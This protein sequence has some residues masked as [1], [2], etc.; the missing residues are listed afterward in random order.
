MFLLCDR[1]RILAAL[2]TLSVST[3]SATASDTPANYSHILPL[4]ISANQAVVPL[5]LP[6]AVYLAARSPRLHD[7][8]VFDSD[9]VA[10]QFALAQLA[11]PVIVSQSSMPVA[12]FPLYGPALE[13]GRNHAGLQ[14]RTGS[15][16]ALISVTAPARATEDELLSLVLDLRPAAHAAQVGAASPVGALTL[17]LPPG[18]RNYHARVALDV[19]D[20][21]QNWEEWAEASVSWL[22]NDQGSAVQKHRIDVAPRAFRYA[23]IRW[24]DGKPVVFSAV[25]AEYIVEHQAR[26]HLE[27]IALQGRMSADGVDLLY[28]APVAIPVSSLGLVFQGQN[29]V[30]PAMVGQYRAASKHPPGKPVSPQFVPLV[31]TTFF[32]L[33]QDGKRRTS[34]DIEVPVTHSVQWVVRPLSGVSERPEL[35]LQW[36]SATVVFIASGTAPYRLAFG[37]ANARPA[38][39]EL[40]QVAPGF[41]MRELA[42]LP[43]AKSGEPVQQQASAMGA[44][45]SA[46]GLAGDKRR[47]L[48]AILLAGVAA[49]AAMAWHLIR[50]LKNGQ[51]VPPSA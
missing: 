23:R 26:R 2:V 20:D 41:T 24:L 43:L 36:E 31:N 12:V 44:P 33:S 46:S 40:H 50:Q 27:S 1:D 10:M 3:T 17:A 29:V 21:L 14:I 4:S 5:R 22:A 35:R 49:L 48:W 47:W 7:L 34:G 19:S 9:G 32:Q 25:N 15:D 8:N 18:V 16:G 45:D 6:R 11:P 30:M 51:S 38:S 37:R 28:T 39:I 13:A 42:A